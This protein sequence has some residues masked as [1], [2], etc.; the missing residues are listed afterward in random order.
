MNM[1]KQIFYIYLLLVLAL[2]TGCGKFLTKQPQQQITTS[3]FWKTNDDILGGIAAMYNGVQQQCSYNYFAYG[4]GRTDNFWISQYGNIAFSINGLSNATNGT[5]WSPIYTTIERANDLLMHVPVIGASQAGQSIGATA[6][7]NY[8]AQAYGVRAYCYFTLLRIFGGAPVWRVPYDSVGQA[9]F[10]PQSS[11][12][13]LMDS[14]VIPDL[15][16]AATLADTTQNTVWYV[17]LGGI[18]AM[19]MDVYMWKHDYTN[20]IYWY[21]KLMGMNRYAL[22]PTATWKNLFIAPQNSKESIWSL[23]WD[24]TVNG[25]ANIS[26]EI[27]AGNTNSQ[28]WISDV[29]W[30]YFTTTTADIRGAQSIDFKQKNHDKVNK[31]YPVNLDSKGVQ[32]YPANNQANVYFALYRLA[33]LILLRAEA[34][35]CTGDTT[36]AINLVNQVHTRAGL[37]AWTMTQLVDSTTISQAILRE[38][39]WELFAEGKRWYDLV[40]NGVVSYWLDPIMLKKFPTAQTYASDP[41]KILWPINA[42]DLNANP[43]LVQNP[44]Y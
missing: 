31:F 3:S 34:A 41:R 18:R 10:I 14:L 22:E 44:P 26:G 15:M 36:T 24:W 35:N 12:Q 19:L 43:A 8:M 30:T 33:D 7:N 1:R 17:N 42:N 28:W 20:A 13:Y 6:I 40:R 29:I 39:Q 23:T 32:I 11:A 25:G 5:D 9:K 4:D 21:N 27:G 2:G 16:N 38:R 37:P